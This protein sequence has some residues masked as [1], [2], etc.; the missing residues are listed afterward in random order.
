MTLHLFHQ[1]PLALSA[2]GQPQKHPLQ[3]GVTKT[4]PTFSPLVPRLCLALVGKWDN[5]TRVHLRCQTKLMGHTVH[6]QRAR[7]PESSEEQTPKHM[8]GTNHQ[9]HGSRLTWPQTIISRWYPRQHWKKKK[10]C[11]VECWISGKQP[12]TRTTF[13]QESNKVRKCMVLP[14]W[15]SF[16]KKTTAT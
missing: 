14:Q 2:T 13:P 9:W 10:S 6:H 8:Q 3:F 11:R 15:P 7:N 16:W 4:C 1:L 12:M 5:H